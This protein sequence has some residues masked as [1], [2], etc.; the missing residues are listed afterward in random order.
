MKN[1]IGLD[2]KV[3][4]PD[5]ERMHKLLCEGAGEEILILSRLHQVIVKNKLDVSLFGV[6]VTAFRAMVP[7]YDT[8]NCII[9]G[10]HQCCYLLQKERGYIE[11]GEFVATFLSVFYTATGTPK[12]LMRSTGNFAPFIGQVLYAVGMLKIVNDNIVMTAGSDKYQEV[13]KEACE[14]IVGVFGESIRSGRQETYPENR[15]AELLLGAK[16]MLQS[17]IDAFP[18]DF[19]PEPFTPTVASPTLGITFKGRD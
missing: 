13:L 8:A 3:N 11:S 4:D 16:S 7:E 14:E 15:K 19:V 9:T 5:D 10:T 17:M 12:A 2:G 6:H 1:S 18:K